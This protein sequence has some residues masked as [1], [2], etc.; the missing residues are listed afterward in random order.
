MY[1]DYNINMY[2]AKCH[3]H[4]HTHSHGQQH[5]VHISAA[6]ERLFST[7]GNIVSPL[8]S[9]LKPSKVD[10]LVFLSKNLPA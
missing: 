2:T 9:C 1:G 10:M 8:R 7:S 6:S 3:T 5:R 4:T